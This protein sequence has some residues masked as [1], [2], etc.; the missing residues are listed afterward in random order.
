MGIL[1][2]LA[3]VGGGGGSDGAAGASGSDV[4]IAAVA[5]VVVNCYIKSQIL[6]YL[7][8]PYIGPDLAGQRGGTTMCLEK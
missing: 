8:F 2:G 6:P 7:D 3:G 4:D 5:V 1:A